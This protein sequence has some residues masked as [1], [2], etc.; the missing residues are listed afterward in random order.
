MYYK[1]M[2]TKYYNK[3]ENIKN[4]RY[5]DSLN[6]LFFANRRYEYIGQNILP[7]WVGIKNITV[8]KERN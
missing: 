3:K 7:S 8:I 6:D 2:V 4:R 5:Y 1:D